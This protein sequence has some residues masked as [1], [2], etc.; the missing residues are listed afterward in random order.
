MT[1]LLMLLIIA[2]FVTACGERVEPGKTASPPDVVTGLTTLVVEPVSVPARYALPGTVESSDRGLLTAR[3]PGQVAQIVVKEGQSLQPG[4]SILHIS[5]E[6]AT[7]E[8]QSAVSGVAVAERQLAEAQAYQSLAEATFARYLKLHETGAVT[9]HEFDRV[10]ADLDA[11]EQRLGAAK[12]SLDASRAQRRTAKTMADQATV[13]APYAAEVAE[14]M[15]D[16]GSTLQP[17]TPLLSLDR[18]GL[19]QVRVALPESLAGRHQVGDRFSVEL[20]TLNKLLTG[21][22]T[23]LQPGADP[24][25]RTFMAWLSLPEEATL[26]NGLFARVLVS[27]ETG[28]TTLLIPSAAVVTRGQLTGV[29]VVEDDI[30]HYRLVRTG[31]VLADQVEILSGLRDGEELIVA[32]LARAHNGARLERK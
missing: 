16:V 32:D 13:R 26:K 15:I 23:K 1:R 5:G 28:A 7:S 20:P 11:A 21:T 18:S 22:L 3:I 9:P 25:S 10:K 30:L 2:L 4:D 6:T 19:M 31:R 17:G 14:I 27:E 12:A 8:L 29:Y 24:H